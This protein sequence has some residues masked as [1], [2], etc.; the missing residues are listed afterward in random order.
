MGVVE[1]EQEIDRSFQPTKI[2]K[3]CNGYWKFAMREKNT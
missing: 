3:V 2:A 1:Q